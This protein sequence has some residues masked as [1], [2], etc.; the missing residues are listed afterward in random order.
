MNYQILQTNS[1]IVGENRDLTIKSVI[2]YHAEFFSRLSAASQRCK[3]VFCFTVHIRSEFFFFYSFLDRQQRI[4]SCLLRHGCHRLV[5]D[6]PKVHYR[7]SQ[8]PLLPVSWSMWER[9]RETENG[10]RVPWERVWKL[11]KRACYYYACVKL[12][13]FHRN[14]IL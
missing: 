5:S 3:T 4:L 9:P 6:E 11:M 2:S 12:F 8:C 10:K 14:Q 1:V 7:S 13:W